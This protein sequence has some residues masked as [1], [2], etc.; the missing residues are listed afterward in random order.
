MN[1]Y[2]NLIERKLTDFVDEEHYSDFDMLSNLRYS[3]EI[4]Y[5]QQRHIE[6]VLAWLRL[7]RVHSLADWRTTDKEDPKVSRSVDS[8]VQQYEYLLTHVKALQAQCQDSITNSTSKINLN[9]VKSSYEQSRRIGRLTFLAAV[10]APMAFTTSFFA[11]NIGLKNLSLSNWVVVTI[12]LTSATLFFM[13]VDVL[14][15]V[16]PRYLRWREVVKRAMY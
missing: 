14:G 13:V 11:M 15:W 3:K 10:F 8:V 6:H 7:H 16:K 4:L 2:N 12:I 9:E 1:Q 5:R